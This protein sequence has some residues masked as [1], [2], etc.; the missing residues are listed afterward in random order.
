MLGTAQRLL[1]TG[2]NA[3]DP[4]ESIRLFR[5][6]PLLFLSPVSQGAPWQNQRVDVGGGQE[7][8]LN[9]LIHHPGRQAFT[10]L[11]RE[12][13]LGAQVK[14]DRPGLSRPTSEP[15]SRPALPRS[16]MPRRCCGRRPG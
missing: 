1:A 15:A 16:S 4:R 11:A 5:A 10:N 12:V 14:R 2:E 6:Q 7:A 13:Q 9:N 8:G 3:Y